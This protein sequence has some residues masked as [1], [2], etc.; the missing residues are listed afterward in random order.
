VVVRQCPIDVGDIEVVSIRDGLRRQVTV[1]DSVGD[2]PNGDSTTVDARFA[3]H[4]FL[5]PND[6]GGPSGHV[7]IDGRR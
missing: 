4:H 6:A 5:V 3:P 2:L 7:S 1:L